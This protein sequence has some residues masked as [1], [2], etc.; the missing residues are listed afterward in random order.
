MKEKVITLVDTSTNEIVGL[1]IV[2]EVEFYYIKRKIVTFI[3]PLLKGLI[4]SFIERFNKIN[5]NIL[6]FTQK[7]YEE[8]LSSPEG[9]N[10]KLLEPYVLKSDNN[11]KTSRNN[12]ML[13]DMGLYDKLERCVFYGGTQD[14]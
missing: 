5:V 6:T 1:I 13:K 12:R 4:N 2:E 9:Y 14:Y 3:N 7:L 8:L 11:N 10:I